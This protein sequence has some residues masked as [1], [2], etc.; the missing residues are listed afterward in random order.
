MA[1]NGISMLELIFL[2]LEKLP[3]KVHY[4]AHIHSNIHDLVVNKTDTVNRSFVALSRFKKEA[5]EPHTSEIC[6]LYEREV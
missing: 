1:G 3:F 6:S 5:L 4:H 2:T